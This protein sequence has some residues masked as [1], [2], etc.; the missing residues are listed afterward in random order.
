MEQE[1][2]IIACTQCKGIGLV[3][4]LNTDGSPYLYHGK[5]LTETCPLCEG[6]GRLLQVITIELY[7]IPVENNV[8][9]EP[10]PQKKRGILNGIF[11]KNK[12]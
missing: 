12:N 9:D 11:K 3:Q 1:K 5:P 7:R 6:T 10:Q 2:K 4:R 8:I